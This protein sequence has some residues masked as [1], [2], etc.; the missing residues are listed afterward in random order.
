MGVL[1]EWEERQDLELGRTAS[2]V[3][4]TQSQQENT[5][6]EGHAAPV[7]KGG[8]AEENGSYQARAAEEAGDGG[9]SEGFARALLTQA[10]EK[11]TSR[12]TLWT[13]A[14]HLGWGT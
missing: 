1:R 11:R 7:A 4:A 13:W 12:R 2:K 6:N 3:G 5:R 9:P 14:S 10:G 8:Q